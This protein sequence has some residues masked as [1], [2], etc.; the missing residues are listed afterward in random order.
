[1]DD[2]YAPMHDLLTRPAWHHQVACRGHS[3]AA[4]F[5]ER[6]QL[7]VDVVALC[8]SCP[9]REQCAVWAIDQGE[10]LVDVFGGLSSRQRRG[11]RMGR[12]TRAEALHPVRER[13]SV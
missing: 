4:F 10:T 9:V 7:F 2:D 12:L 1:V 5:P 3:T 13:K 11:I 8:R 6:G